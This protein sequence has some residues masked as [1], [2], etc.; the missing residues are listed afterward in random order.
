MLETMKLNLSKPKNVWYF[1]KPFKLQ[2]LMYAGPALIEAYRI[3]ES[4][5]WLGISLSRS[6]QERAKSNL[7]IE[8]PVP[9]ATGH[10][11][12]PVVNWPAA[13][14]HD[15]KIQPPISTPQF[16]KAFELTFGPYE[17]LTPEVQIKYKN[18]VDFFNEQLKQHN[19]AS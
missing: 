1:Q 9:V 2:Y 4:A 19:N 11:Y 6:F 10:D 14:E 18:T 17:L 8:W 3:G 5:K 16:Y 13:F 7:I 15:L 12:R